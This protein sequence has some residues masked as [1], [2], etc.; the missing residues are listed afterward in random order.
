MK[1]IT[2]LFETVGG[3]ENLVY[4]N[5]MINI[6]DPSEALH[7]RDGASEQN[8]LHSNTLIGINGQRI[9]L[10]EL[11]ITEGGTED[12]N[13][14]NTGGNGDEDEDEEGSTN[15]GNDSGNGEGESDS[16]NDSET[17]N[18]NEEVE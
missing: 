7:L 4:N 13:E 18:S 14:N 6:P 1:F 9:S 2:I 8:T 12:S 5:T 17:S 15:N 16:E 11:A 10:D 3:V